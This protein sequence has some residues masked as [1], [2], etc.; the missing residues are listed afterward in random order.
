MS[1]SSI[2]SGLSATLLGNS[3]STLSTSSI[4]SELLAA[5]EQGASGSSDALTSAIVSLGSQSGSSD[6]ST[7]TYNAQGLL[8]LLQTSTQLADPLLQSDS[9]GASGSST[10]SM[11]SVLQEALLLSGTSASTGATSSSDTSSS[12]SGSGSSTTSGSTDLNS[13]WTQVLKQNPALA[14]QLVQSE[15]DQGLLGQIG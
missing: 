11:D 9:S 13:D 5:V 4:G 14:T 8:S 3:A 7:A 1:V 15:V 6:G 12:S 2:S 10:S